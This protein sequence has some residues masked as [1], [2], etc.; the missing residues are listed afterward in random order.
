MTQ[1]HEQPQDRPV[2]QQR[3]LDRIQDLSA[4]RARLLREGYEHPPGAGDVPVLAW[5]TQLLHLGADRGEVET[6]ARAIGIGED[7]I[8]A[9]RAAGGHGRLAA[10]PGPD[11]DVVREHMVTGVA[12]DVWQ[13][14]HMAVLDV[15]RRLR[16]ITTTPRFEPGPET[17]AQFE[18]NMGAF[19][20]RAGNV[21]DAIGLTADEHAGMW[22]T[23][24]SE[25]RRIVD[26]TAQTY[27]SEGIEERWRIYARS[28]I[29]SELVRD[30][31][32]MRLPLERVLS[33]HVTRIPAPKTM[34]VAAAAAF[35][36]QPT[37]G[38]G[39]VDESVARALP[40][41]ADGASWEPPSSGAPEP[42]D[43]GRD[44]GIAP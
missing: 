33:E 6:H 22:A 42:P 15:A 26:A 1:S 10:G 12:N 3:L 8:A 27:D 2:W 31:T 13:M 28:G 44:T 20:L 25:W 32:A 21:A 37:V 34:K 7:D 9:E 43:R 5:R 40:V 14:Q 29:E 16:R 19:W 35:V 30:A 39:E 36:E 24:S 4:H 38:L 41:E 17:V 23:T 18:R 11:V